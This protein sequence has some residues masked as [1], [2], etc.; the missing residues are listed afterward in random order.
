[1]T[2]RKE[3]MTERKEGMTERKEGKNERKEEMTDLLS[4]FLPFLFPHQLKPN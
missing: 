2:E 3:G 4:C 1:M